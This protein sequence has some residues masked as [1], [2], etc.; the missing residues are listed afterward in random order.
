VKTITLVAAFLLV[1][2]PALSDATITLSLSGTA[3]DTSR[4]IILTNAD[5]ARVLA[6]ARDEGPQ[7]EVAPISSDPEVCVEPLPA[8]C[9]PTFR[10]MTAAEAAAWLFNSMLADLRVRVRNGERVKASKTAI[11]AVPPLTPQ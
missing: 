5:G 11:D 8:E 7:V 9:L 6:W 1:A 3:V 4:A 10:Q 2:S